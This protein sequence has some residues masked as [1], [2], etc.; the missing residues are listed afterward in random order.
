MFSQ[1]N[2][3]QKTPILGQEGGLQQKFFYNLCFAKCEEL[4]FLGGGI[5]WAQIWLM[6][7]KH[8]KNR[9]FSTFLAKKGKI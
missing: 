9:Y 5:F 6:F 2:R 7:K 1:K 4:S 3:I 8:C